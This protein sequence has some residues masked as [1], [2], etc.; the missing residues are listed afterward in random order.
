MPLL[1]RE[2]H[3]HIQDG[4][5]G[6]VAISVRHYGRVPNLALEFS[7]EV[8]SQAVNK[9]RRTSREH[10]I[11]TAASKLSWTAYRV[12]EAH[13]IRERALK[14]ELKLEA[15]AR[16]ASW[17]RPR[18][19]EPQHE[20]HYK[21]IHERA[22]YDRQRDGPPHKLKEQA[23]PS[24]DHSDSW[25]DALLEPLERPD[26]RESVETLT[27]QANRELREAKARQPKVSQSE[28][29]AMQRELTD[30]EESLRDLVEFKPD[31]ELSLTEIVRR[32]AQIERPVSRPSRSRDRGR[33]R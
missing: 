6:K 29:K 30:R 31:Q 16:R 27:Q 24:R 13:L 12:V 26:A 4:H 32:E 3:I 21:S 20:S 17:T 1:E 22:E 7:P 2:P 5:D 28:R 18:A 15:K 11:L 10:R 14:V 23:Q 19:E 8:L 25:F 9:W 33:S